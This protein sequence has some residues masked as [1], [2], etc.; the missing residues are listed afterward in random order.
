MKYSF[1]LAAL[2]A[3]SVLADEDACTCHTIEEVEAPVVSISTV[4]ASMANTTNF[5]SPVPAP[6]VDIHDAAFVV[7]QAQV[8]LHY[9]SNLTTSATVNVTHTM[10]YPTVV[11]EQIA[12]IVAV[13]C[14]STSVAM[15]F[16][17]SDVFDTTQA[18]WIADE[19]MIFITNH[20][21]DCD[22]VLERGFFL[23]NS[24]SFNNSTLIATASSMKVNV[25]STAGKLMRYL[26]R[27][28]Y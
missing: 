19:T 27:K 5:F 3:A 11:L 14:S 26:G 4:P 8:S 13:D 7:P 17:D 10:K 21:G 16:N 28:S 20:L 2:A 6:G 25:S 12:S 22:P 15:T 24:L 1:G 18:A 9:G 23:S